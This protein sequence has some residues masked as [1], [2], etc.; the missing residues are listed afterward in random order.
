M[1]QLFVFEHLL[2][3]SCCC[4]TPLPLDKILKIYSHM[5]NTWVHLPEIAFT[6]LGWIISWYTVTQWKNMA[7]M[8]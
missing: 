1:L 8:S 7:R 4:L 6:A 2:V 3:S 5:C